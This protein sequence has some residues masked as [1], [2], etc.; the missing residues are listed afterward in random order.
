MIT[1][2]FQANHII[3]LLEEQPHLRPIFTPK[4]VQ[5]FSEAKQAALNGILE[6]SAIHTISIVGI[7]KYDNSY[8]IVINR[9]S[10]CQL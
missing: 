5:T 10:F 4:E 2:R 9:E 8:S 1:V 7:D 6:C 3:K